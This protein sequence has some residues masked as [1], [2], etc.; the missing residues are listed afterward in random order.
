MSSPDAKTADQHADNWAELVEVLDLIH[1]ARNF[2]GDCPKGDLAMCR[3]ATAGQQ[4]LPCQ[5]YIDRGVAYPE[6]WCLLERDQDNKLGTTLF[7]RVQKQLRLLQTVIHFGDW[8][9]EGFHFSNLSEDRKYGVEIP[10]LSTDVMDAYGRRQQLVPLSEQHGVTWTPREDPKKR[11]MQRIFIANREREK[12][13][14]FVN[15]FAPSPKGGVWISE[16]ERQNRILLVPD[17]ELSFFSL[18]FVLAAAVAS[19]TERNARAWVAGNPA[20]LRAELCHAYEL[21]EERAPG[22]YRD[23]FAG[24]PEA[25]YR[26][27]GVENYVFD[28]VTFGDATVVLGFCDNSL[29]SVTPRFQRLVEWLR[30]GSAGRSSLVSHGKLWRLGK[31]ETLGQLLQ[32]TVGELPDHKDLDIQSLKTLCFGLLDSLADVQAEDGRPFLSAPEHIRR[33]VSPRFNIL[34]EFLLRKRE[35][36]SRSY[37]ASPLAFFDD[38]QSGATRVGAFA[39][40]TLLD[41]ETLDAST[42][43]R[44][45]ALRALLRAL[46]GF[47]MDRSFSSLVSTRTKAS[48]LHQVPKDMAAVSM[49]LT[50]H[51][52]DLDSFREKHPDLHVP[53]FEMP[54]SMS[55]LLM[56]MKA[57]SEHKLYELPSDCAEILGG[58][59]NTQ[60]LA[61]FVERVVWDTVPSRIFA[62]PEIIRE[63]QAGQFGWSDWEIEDDSLRPIISVARPFA[64]AAPRYGLYPLV[65]LALRNACQ[66]AFRATL[67]QGKPA[68]PGHVEIEALP[69]RLG[70][71]ILNTGSPPEKQVNQVAQSGW[72]RDLKVFRDLTGR[73]I[74][75]QRGRDRYSEFE[76]RRSRWVTTIVFSAD[77]GRKTD[78]GRPQS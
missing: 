29:A 60:S 55:V 46:A 15:L 17:S 68:K 52:R 24:R 53:E 59:W 43:P 13:A 41:T 75:E 72:I 63:R 33:F 3:E 21:D 14:E 70:V 62:D 30:S 76:A 4:A 37:F 65:I 47:G 22:T 11:H 64:L 50:R 27:P 73:W 6:A 18:L 45:R 1:L 39:L 40:G 71:Q 78:D 44:I 61:T 35:S 34:G 66:H 31:A 9:D 57:E 51:K 2:A 67:K 58:E 7:H 25:Q 19:G 49:K 26:L 20:K 8:S 23:F 36:A 16:Y 10:W 32:P 12:L 48:L 54:D 5:R 74:V 69:D 42:T 56:F 77:I 38:D 28:E